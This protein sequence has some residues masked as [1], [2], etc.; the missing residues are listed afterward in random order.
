LAIG[1]Q[2]NSW[3]GWVRGLVLLIL[4]GVISH[5]YYWYWPRLHPWQPRSTSQVAGLVLGETGLDLRLWMPFPHQNLGILERRLGGLGSLSVA[6]QELLGTAPLELPSFGPFR[7]PPA[8]EMAIATDREGTGFVAAARVYPV[9][10]WL[11]RAAGRL[12]SNP[13]MAGGEL[14]LGGRRVRVEWQ[15]SLW[16]ATTENVELGPQ[17]IQIEAGRCLALL[18][19][20]RQLGPVPGGLFRFMA[21]GRRFVLTSTLQGDSTLLP[22]VSDLRMDGVALSW[23][24]ITD[25]GEAQIVQALVAL[26][27]PGRNMGGLPPLMA[28]QTAGSE[29]MRLPGERILEA[30]GA[31][32]YSRSVGEWELRSYGEESLRL[33]ENL[34]AQLDSLR[35][36][37]GKGGTVSMGFVDLDEA[38]RALLEVGQGLG[39]VPVIGENEARR[40]LAFARLLEGMTDY[41]EM[42]IWLADPDRLKIEI[43]P[44]SVD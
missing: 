18:R 2:V 1:D 6:M 10:A 33:G 44:E 7:L 12:A 31:R 17:D 42:S 41:S 15:G 36:D 13:W 8:R 4:I 21:A 22:G 26:S 25:S 19:L 28:V 3:R 14:V 43:R 16:L 38:R 40:W 23:T 37:V 39:Q 11:F 9:A 34:V 5:L 29:T 27:G 30:V 35:L 24:R 20:G 32:V